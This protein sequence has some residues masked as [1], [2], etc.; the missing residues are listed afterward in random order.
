MAAPFAHVWSPLRAGLTHGAMGAGVGALA[1]TGRALLADAPQGETS[2]DKFKRVATSAGQWGLGTGLAVGGYSALKQHNFRNNLTEAHTNAHNTLDSMAQSTNAAGQAAH[3]AGPF[4]SQP[5]KPVLSAQ[6][7]AGQH[8]DVDDMTGRMISGI[9]AW[10]GGGW[11]GFKG[12]AAPL[13][14]PLQGLWSPLRA[15]LTHGAMGA[16]GGGLLGAG[17]GAT[18]A[19]MQDGPAGETPEQRRSRILS[20]AGKWGLGGAAAG[21]LAAG[22]YSAV[23]QHDHN[24][25]LSRGYKH[26]ASHIIEDGTE[27]AARAALDAKYRGHA[28]EMPSWAG[29]GWH[30]MGSAGVAPE[31]MPFTPPG[32]PVPPKEGPGMWERVRK[33]VLPE[34]KIEVKLSAAYEYG[35]WLA[36][37]T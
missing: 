34:R 17:V 21:G 23:S 29:R 9:N 28:T 5:Y 33:A 14:A 6:D 25:V 36:S 15:G 8:R 37:L 35:V 27:G 13:P 24:K 12:A 19:V 31:V 4:A 18:K 20:S 11:H 3:E 2:G 16:A 30:G 10:S 26:D 7:I 32:K 1:G 22:G